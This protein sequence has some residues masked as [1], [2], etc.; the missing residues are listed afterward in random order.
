MT[1]I[2]VA[3]ILTSAALHPLREYLIKKDASPKGVTLAVVFQ[4]WI[5]AGIEVWL[6]GLSPLDAYQVWPMMLI[7][8]VGLLFYY[9]CVVM[10]LRTG[11]LSIY[12]PITRSSPIFV[13]FVGYLFLGHTYSASMLAGIGLVL[14]AAFSLQYKRG[15]RFFS[16]PLTLTFAFLAMCGH[17][18]ITLADA[19]AM[20]HVEPAVFVFV[21]YICLV[22]AMAVLLT[23]TSAPDDDVG[24]IFIH[25]WV[26]TPM[27][28]F[29]AGVT[30]YA[31]YY[32]I[33]L[34]FQL[35]AN[36]AALSAVR[37]ISIPMSVLLGGMMLK[38]KSMAGRLLWS[39]LLAI[40]IAVIIA[41]K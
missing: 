18:V 26:K 35:G 9:W 6:R 7:S 1:P 12:Y 23:L 27:R 30:A 15:A 24:R 25:G 22:P 19:E 41:S 13:V 37:Q 21:L 20:K 38:E 34:A 33:L 5:Y 2:I 8:G 28:Y 3:L 40:G 14:V 31:S 17:G 16:Q 4:F 39:V 10:T 11:D 29:T 32:L 36:V